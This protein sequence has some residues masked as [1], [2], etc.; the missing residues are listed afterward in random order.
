M[1]L[2]FKVKKCLCP[3]NKIPANDGTGISIIYT[4]YSSPLYPGSVD[5]PDVTPRVPVRQLLIGE[6]P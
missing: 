2:L 6:V 4:K 1:A 3:A 5:V